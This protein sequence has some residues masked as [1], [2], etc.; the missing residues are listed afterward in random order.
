MCSGRGTRAW[1]RPPANS[2]HHRHHYS[3]HRTTE[4]KEFQTH[5]S[6]RAP[7]LCTSKSRGSPN[8][9]NNALQIENAT[10][11]LI[12]VI[13]QGIAAS[14]P[15]AKPCEFSNPDFA[16]ECREAVYNTRR[17]RKIHKA[18]QEPADWE[19]Y[20][21]AR[22]HKK[23]TVARALRQGHRQRVAE[24]TEDPRGLWK[25]HKWAR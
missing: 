17:L 4:T 19:R 10:N 9:I 3:S 24:A 23:H 14:M 13:N 1:L 16:P 2:D 20:S 6:K 22:N 15:W 5:G 8:Q 25:I 18:T 7:R 12:E 21:E 11:H